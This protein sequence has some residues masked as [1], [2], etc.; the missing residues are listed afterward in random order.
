MCQT[1]DDFQK[2]SECLGAYEPG[3]VYTSAAATLFRYANHG[4]FMSHDPLPDDLG[5]ANW[6]YR[7][8]HVAFCL[9]A[10]R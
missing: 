10:S 6:I 7:A 9:F 3:V 2:L 8:A 4:I 1:T 5:Q